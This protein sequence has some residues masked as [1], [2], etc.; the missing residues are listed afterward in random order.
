MYPWQKILVPTDFSTA[1]QWVFDDAVRIAASTGAE[2]L[3]VHVRITRGTSDQLRFPADDSVYEYAESQE[4]ELLRQRMQKLNAKVRTRMIVRKG[5]DPADEIQ[6]LI[7]EESVDLIVIATHARHLVAQLL[8]G[9]TT[10]GLLKRCSVPLIAI[11]YGIRKRDALKHVATAV[12][13]VQESA[14]VRELIEKIATRENATVRLL[15]PDKQFGVGDLPSFF[16]SE[17]VS[18]A[19]IAEKK[20]EKRTIKYVESNPTDLLVIDSDCRVSGELDSSVEWIVRHANA[21]VM[22]VPSA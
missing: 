17:R 19:V 13:V 9:S 5:P 6:Q 15:A 14:A 8:V 21:P 12:E 16:R 20:V 10:T 1:A 3:V 22:V 2:I 11:R 4:L 18:V 7:Q